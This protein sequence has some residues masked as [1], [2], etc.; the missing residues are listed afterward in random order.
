MLSRIDEGGL[1]M[2]ATR[3]LP[4]F[5]TVSLFLAVPLSLPAHATFPGTNGFIAFQTGGYGGPGACPNIDFVDPA[6]PSNVQQFTSCPP[7]VGDPRWSSNASMIAVTSQGD[8]HNNHIGTISTSSG[9]GS[10]QAVTTT[11]AS[12]P[13][14]PSLNQDGSLIAFGAGNAGGGDTQNVFT[15]SGSG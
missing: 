10:I 6:N 8:N 2:R 5:L 13:K 1:E 9:D 14:D 3:L 15:V 4:V 7:F 11:G 12:G